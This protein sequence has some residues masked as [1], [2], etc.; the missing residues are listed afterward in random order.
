VDLTVRTAVRSDLDALLRLYAQLYPEVERPAGVDD[1]A[2]GRALMGAA[3]DVGGAAGCYKL[4]L[5]TANPEAFLFY[6]ALGL[7]R[8]GRVHKRYWA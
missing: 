6:E 5:P 2:V 3:M 7:E 8:A 1:A 4:Q